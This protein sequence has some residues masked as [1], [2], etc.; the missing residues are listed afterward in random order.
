VCGPPANLYACNDVGLDSA[1]QMDLHPLAV[2]DLTAVLLIEPPDESARTESGAQA[3]Q[4][5]IP[6]QEIVEQLKA[7]ATFSEDEMSLLLKETA[8]PRVA[9]HGSWQ[10]VATRY[11]A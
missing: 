2:V 3:R 1:H 9:G 6:A 10:S 4:V 7:A 8:H 5:V 11:S